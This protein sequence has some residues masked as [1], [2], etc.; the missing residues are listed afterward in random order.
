M[1]NEHLLK[2]DFSKTRVLVVGDVMLD[3][4]WYGGVGRISPE[5]P[6]PVVHVNKSEERP[7][8]AGNVAL[9]IKSLG[10]AVTLL[11]VIGEDDAG[12]CLEER[13]KAADIDCHLIHENDYPTVT[14]LRVISQHQQLIRLDFEEEKHAVDVEPLL[15]LFEAQLKDADIVLLSDYA[16]GVLTNPLPFIEI[17]KQAGVP[18]FADPKQSNFAAYQGVD[19]VTPNMKEF[20]EAVGR[21]DQEEML[22]QKAQALCTQHHLGAVLL[23]RGERGMTLIRENQDE[24]HIPTQ[25]KEVFDVT[26]AGDTVIAVFATAAASGF[27]IE[28][29]M[30]MANVAAG[31]VVAKLGAATVT[32][33]ELRRALRSKKANISG[34]LNL[35]QLKLAIE[36]AHS[37]GEK[38]VFTNGC[39]D[40]LHAG[41]MLYLKEA[42]TLGERLIVAVNAD[43]TVAQLK[44]PGR[45]VNS[46]DKRMAVLAG[47]AAVDWVIPFSEATPEPLL[48]ALHPD[49]LVKGGDYADNEVVGAE[50]VK[51]YGGEV[52]ALGELEG[53]STTHLIKK[54]QNKEV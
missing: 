34:I 15:A 16:K 30:R 22:V 38:V 45:P 4:Y 49:V 27:S 51:A 46:L 54:I 47:I 40:I 44:G 1:S 7:G 9:N 19:C 23:T 28:D 10:A 48:E 21:C 41:H 14:K 2:F 24:L 32:T 31:L 43:E 26:G 3:R 39:F 50:I 35:E 36:E 52:K 8:G 18:V 6:V 42:K 12:R 25:A 17:A 5:A 33:P 37:V 29:A 13:L 20:E 53:L 11:G